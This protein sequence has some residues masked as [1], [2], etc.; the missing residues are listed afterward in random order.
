LT[1]IEVH[2]FSPESLPALGLSPDLNHFML[3]TNFDWKSMSITLIDPFKPL[4]PL[5]GRLIPL[6]GLSFGLEFE[7]PPI[8]D[9]EGFVYFINGVIKLKFKT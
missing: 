3:V 8:S 4:R 9:L 1:L 7:H 6:N 2:G 5:R